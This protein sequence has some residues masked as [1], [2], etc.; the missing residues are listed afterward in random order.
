MFNPPMTSKEAASYRYGEWA[1]RPQGERY[2]HERCA[3][4]TMTDHF[5]F[6][7]CRRYPGH[8]PAKLYCRQHAKIVK[9]RLGH[10]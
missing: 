4:E 8:G 1:G 7:Q 5:I 10:E 2:N 9:E 6:R 3:Y